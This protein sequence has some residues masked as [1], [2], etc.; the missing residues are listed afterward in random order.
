MTN[1]FQYGGIVTEDAF[2]NREKETRD[3]LRAAQ[4]GERLL[5]YAERRMG[6]TSLVRRVLNALPRAEYLTVYI[7]L[8]ATSGTDSFVEAV[9]KAVTEAGAGPADKMLK[10]ATELFRHLVPSLTVDESGQPSIQFGARAAAPP[11]PHLEEALDAPHRLAQ[12]SGR[13]VVVVYD[14]IQRIAEYGDDLVERVLRSR[15]QMHGDVSYFFLGSRK[16]L[17]RR[18]FMEEGRPFYQSSGHYPIGMIGAAHWLPFIRERFLAADKNIEDALV[19][20]L[21]EH[22][23]GHPY[24]TQHLAHDL[25]ELSPGGEQVTPERLQ[26]AENLLLQRL[27]YAYS[28]L[29]ESLTSNQQQLLRTLAQARPGLKPTSA[30]AVR[31]HGLAGSSVHRAAEGLFEKDLIDRDGDA[32][33]VSDRF[34]RLWIARL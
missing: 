22:T 27:T 30:E 20:A 5:V 14:E 6:K 18:M 33:V 7:D 11:V 10:T 13:R 29:W 17:V 23:E 12:K 16:H 28:V 8:W 19:L 34:F 4:N 9:A 3:L 24:Y 21:C 25:W 15:V 2:C 1:P 32:Y 31:Q 26:E